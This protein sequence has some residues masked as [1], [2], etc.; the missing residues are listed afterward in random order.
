MHRA[1]IAIKPIGAG[2][3][4]T[5][6]M[7]IHETLHELIQELVLPPGERLVEADLAARFGVSKTP[8]REAL[9]LLASEDLVTI[10]PHFGATVTWLSLDDFEQQ[11]FLQDALEQPALPRVVER[12]TRSELDVI[13]QLTDEIAAAHAR[14]DE[15]TYHRLVRQMHEDLF[16]IAGYPR[17]TDLIGAVMQAMRRH[18]SIFVRPFPE[19]WSRDLA[20]IMR[21]FEFI[22][23]GDPTRAAVAVQQG[24]AA[25]LEFVRHRIAAHDPT[26]MPYLASSQDH[27]AATEEGDDRAVL[28]SHH[29]T[30][31][32]G[33]ER[34]TK[35]ESGRVGC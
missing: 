17:I 30:A 33:V 22:H 10:V 24:H 28:A 1:T 16:A 11:L 5:V 12:I 23:I 8:V 20:I 27:T 21:R 29:E 3:R 32:I 35:V 4:R 34:L 9:R 26:V 25:T 14:N 13:G 18:H 6:T 31:A 7:D 2:V 19:N 15:S